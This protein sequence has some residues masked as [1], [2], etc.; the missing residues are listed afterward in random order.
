[1]NRYELPDS[2]LLDKSLPDNEEIRPI[3]ESFDEIMTRFEYCDRY[4]F[5]LI[6][7]DFIEELAQ[8]VDGGT[9]V[10]VACG[11]GW[12]SH[13]LR[14]S[15][16]N[17]LKTTDNKTWTRSEK[18][19]YAP[20]VEIG[21]AV[22]TAERTRADFIILSWP[23]M[24]DLAYHVWSALDKGQRLIY[25]GETGGGCCASDEFFES[26]GGQL[27]YDRRVERLLQWIGIHDICCVLE[28]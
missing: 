20:C 21:D 13:W 11:T 5:P 19:V 27:D 3:V 14:E 8:V 6:T 22:E 9:V 16:V 12:L 15:G 26:V 1:M 28:K 18:R 23:Y 4:S 7:R 24:D 25:I 10:E 2:L 17:V